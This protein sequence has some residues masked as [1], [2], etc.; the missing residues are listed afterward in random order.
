MAG[1][2]TNEFGTERLVRVLFSA[3]WGRSSVHSRKIKAGP[4]W[5]ALLDLYANLKV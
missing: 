4:G 2:L 5:K 3:G 1:T